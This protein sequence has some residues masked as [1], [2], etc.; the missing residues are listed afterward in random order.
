MREL[1]GRLAEHQQRITA[2]EEQEKRRNRRSIFIDGKFALGVEADVVAALGLQTG[3]E[4]GEERL[5]KSST[6]SN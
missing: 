6:P 3:Q 1:G 4:I 5:R 2:I